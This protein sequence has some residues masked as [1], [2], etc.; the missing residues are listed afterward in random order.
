LLNGNESDDYDDEEEE[1][2]KDDDAEGS[3][4]SLYERREAKL[5]EMWNKL[6]KAKQNDEESE[7]A[8]A[9]EE[10]RAQ[11]LGTENEA[12]DMGPS[13]KRKRQESPTEKI[14]AQHCL[15]TFLKNLD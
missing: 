5:A 12:V 14:V 11:L 9:E 3:P 13:L 15:M 1:E 4:Q 6:E 2:S 8:T 10:L 7:A